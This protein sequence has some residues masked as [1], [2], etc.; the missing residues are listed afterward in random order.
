MARGALAHWKTVP[1]GSS[2]F[3]LAQ[4]GGHNP[5]LNRLY[6][7]AASQLQTRQRHIFE[8]SLLALEITESEVQDANLYAKPDQSWKLWKS[9]WTAQDEFDRELDGIRWVGSF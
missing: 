4:K 5:N 7:T 9:P 6:D 1:K 3:L 8:K 2:Q